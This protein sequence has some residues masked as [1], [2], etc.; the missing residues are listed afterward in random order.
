MLGEA[1]GAYVAVA[2]V[3]ASRIA[4]EAAIRR[5]MGALDFELIDVEDVRQLLLPAEAGQ[6]GEDLASR[7]HLLGPDKPI[8]LGHF[9]SFA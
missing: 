8:E 2:G 7:L 9:H 6:L 3:A 4:F 5:A 1:S